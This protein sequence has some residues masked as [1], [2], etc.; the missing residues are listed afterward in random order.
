MGIGP[1]LYRIFFPFVLF[2]IVTFLCVIRPFFKSR[3]RERRKNSGISSE[4]KKK[5]EVVLASILCVI[6]FFYIMY[7]SCD[8]VFRD[9][10]S[11][12]GVFL[13]YYRSARQLLVWNVIFEIDGETESF[14][15]MNSVA[16]INDL[17]PGCTYEVTYAKRTNLVLSIT[18]PPL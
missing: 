3:T 13:K 5:F 12:E 7:L 10:E 17:I 8:L 11:C 18:P 14:I 16:N 15:L 9:F 1:I 2:L 6:C 4:K